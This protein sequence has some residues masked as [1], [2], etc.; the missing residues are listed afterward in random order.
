MQPK[1]TVCVKSAAVDSNVFHI[2]LP[3]TLG[4]TQ[5]DSQSYEHPSLSV[6]YK[7]VHFFFLIYGYHISAVSFLCL[8]TEILIIVLQ[9]L[10]VLSTVTCYTGS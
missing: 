4:V 6:P 9:M 7:G 2:R 1:R 10:T 5:S 8:D 3:L